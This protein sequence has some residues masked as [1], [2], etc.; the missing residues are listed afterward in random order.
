[1]LC[2]LCL[3][4]KATKTNSHFIPVALLN[5]NIG[6]RDYEEA[7]KV[8]PSEE[9]SLDSFKGRNNLDNNDTE[10]KQNPYAADYILC[11]TCEKELSV[12]ENEM[13]PIFSKEIFKDK[14]NQNFQI[15]NTLNEVSY[16]ECSKVNTGIFVLYFYSIVWRMCIQYKLSQE[17]DFIAPDEIEI[18]RKI[19]YDNLPYHMQPKGNIPI[20]K[21][22]FLI[23]T[24]L[25][26][27]INRTSNV[28][29]CH[30]QHEN[31]Y[32]FYINDFIVLIS[33]LGSESL[34]NKIGINHPISSLIINNIRDVVKIGLLKKEGWE[35]RQ[36]DILT[37]IAK[38]LTERYILDL[39]KIT[40]MSLNDCNNLLHS[41][42]KLINEQSGI[43]Y[44]EAFVEG[45]K[46]ITGKT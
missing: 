12:W 24:C 13:N 39:S 7:Y 30:P 38:A 4:E 32:C 1:M 36:E 3:K 37:K 10:I 16:L 43:S 28:A 31:P 15:K 40:G 5:S 46:R 25:S 14:L 9:K 8:S 20:D 11:P 21:I 6:P 26:P 18:L 34:K 44:G 22:P 19:I 2:L 41:Q 27:D 29:L 35:A 42:S 23:S 17:Q 33:F 45:F